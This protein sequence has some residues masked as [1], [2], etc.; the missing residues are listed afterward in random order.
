MGGT[1]KKMSMDDCSPHGGRVTVGPV[2][3]LISE[4]ARLPGVGERT[5][6]R[7]AF[8]LLKQAREAGFERSLAFDLSKTLMM[9]VKEVG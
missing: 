4:L 2:D 9:A 8:Y 6:A 1:F 5:A 7:L 3:R